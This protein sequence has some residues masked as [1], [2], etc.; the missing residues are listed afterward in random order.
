M[1]KILISSI[2]TSAVYL[3]SC[4][5]SAMNNND[6]GT[7]TDTLPPVETNKPNTDYKPAFEGQTRINGVK[8]NTP[9]ESKVITNKL[10]SPWGIAVLPD[11]KLLITEKE[12][13]FRIVYPDG[14][15][16]EPITGAP[17][18]DPSGQGGL[19]GLTLDPDFAS[20]R[21]VYWAFSE[22][23]EGR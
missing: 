10:K 8:T 13:T 23:V 22:P 7:P 9:Y 17:K 14:Q 2:V 1:K 5:N 21:M 15:V 6:N 19:L 4:H 16:S 3:A 11:G 20:N 12:G 18:V